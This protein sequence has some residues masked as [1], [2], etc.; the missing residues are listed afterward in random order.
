MSYNSNQDLNYCIVCEKYHED[1]YF[2]ETTGKCLDCL[3]KEENQT[4]DYPENNFNHYNIHTD[5]KTCKRC[6]KE[7][8]ENYYV[9]HKRICMDCYYDNSESKKENDDEQYIEEYTYEPS[10][11]KTVKF[12]GLFV[13]AL[14]VIIVWLVLSIQ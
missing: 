12:N 10:N 13:V 8:P 14:T 5:L 6:W 9:K 1:A 2:D 3:E 7:V 4:I 11:T